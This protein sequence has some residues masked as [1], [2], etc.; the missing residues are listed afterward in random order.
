LERGASTAITAT[1]TVTIKGVTASSTAGNITLT[2]YFPGGEGGEEVIA[3]NPQNFSVT[4]NQTPIV[5]GID[6]SVWISGSTTS[7]TFS[8]QYFDTNSPT[9]AFSPSAGIG[10]TLSSY[11]DSQI[12]AT[13]NV[14]TGTPNEDVAVSVTNNGYG[15][16]AFYPGASGASPASAP[17]NARVQSPLNTPEIT[18]IG[19]INGQA[20]DIVATVSAGPT[21]P[22]LRTNLTGSSLTC[23]AHMLDWYSRISSNLLT[24]TDIAYANAWLLQQSANPAP[25]PT[26]I[27]P[28]AQQSAGHFR[29]FNDFGSGRGFYQVGS[30]PSPCGG[31]T[32]SWY[33][34]VGNTYPDS[35]PGVSGS[36]EIYQ[37]AEG[38][39]GSAGQKISQTINGRTVPWVWSVIEFN[40]SNAPT[41]SQVGMFPS[42]SVYNNGNFVV[43]Y[44]QS[45]V[46]SFVLNNNTYQLAPSQIP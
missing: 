1:T 21:T 16:S 43:T 19:W 30:T 10:Y 5:T 3:V 35:G 40:S 17:V 37:L 14:A 18:V 8:G 26:T 25:P 42:Y 6:P 39:V 2:A 22:T 32:A 36:G 7:V 33:S 12:V 44:P 13:V 28:A 41:F 31:A 23:L 4:G 29:V 27:T 34:P 11:N 38:Q 15:G 24:P 45:T 46:A 20:P 9:L